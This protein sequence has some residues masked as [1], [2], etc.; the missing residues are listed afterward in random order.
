[1]RVYACTNTVTTARCFL[2]QPVGGMDIS[3]QRCTDSH[4]SRWRTSTASLK[5]ERTRR[6]Y[7]CASAEKTVICQWSILFG[8]VSRR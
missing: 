3:C 2:R 7:T 4:Y 8:V 6:V 1:M 5:Q